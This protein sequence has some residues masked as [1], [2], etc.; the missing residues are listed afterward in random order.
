[1]ARLQCTACGGIYADILPD[2]LRY[3]HVCPPLSVVELTAAVAAGKV[4]LPAGET[5]ADAVQRRTYR[6]A[7]YRNENVVPSRDP[8]RPASIVSAGAGVTEAAPDTSPPP[9]VIV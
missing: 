5:P 4:A 7:T 3:F 8:A 2:G 6:R 1:M 9:I